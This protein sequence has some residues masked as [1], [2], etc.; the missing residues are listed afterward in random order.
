[1]RGSEEVAPHVLS[2]ARLER[3]VDVM[4]RW[5]R[6][7]IKLQGSLLGRDE[8]DTVSRRRC[9]TLW[10]SLSRESFR[11][12]DTVRF[13]RNPISPHLVPSQP[14]SSSA[15]R[16]P[17]NAKLSTIG[18][19]HTAPESPPPLSQLQVQESGHAIEI[20]TASSLT[21]LKVS[22]MDCTSPAPTSTRASAAIID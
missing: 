15:R 17:P 19:V 22:S 3:L 2:S 20:L 18:A 7:D 13:S 4:A 8:W 12:F 6:L 5:E 14:C 16:F 1:M 10:K 21:T 11:Q 9:F